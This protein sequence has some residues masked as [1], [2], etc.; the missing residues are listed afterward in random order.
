MACI[1]MASLKYM[2]CVQNNSSL[3]NLTHKNIKSDFRVCACGSEVP[4]KIN[5]WKSR[6][7]HVTQYPIAGDAKVQVI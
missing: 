1:L 7:R 4:G 2:L 3:N 6:E 5:S